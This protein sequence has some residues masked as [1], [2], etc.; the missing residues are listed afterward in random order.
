MLANALNRISQS[1]DNFDGRKF[2]VN[3]TTPKDRKWTTSNTNV[4]TN[5]TR[6]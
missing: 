3:V 6:T 1:L 4:T 5:T 2:E